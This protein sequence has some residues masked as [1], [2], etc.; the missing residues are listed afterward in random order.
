MPRSTSDAEVASVEAAMRSAGLP[1]WCVW[2]FAL[3]RSV[4]VDFMEDVDATLT[5]ATAGKSPSLLHVSRTHGVYR[6][7]YQPTLRQR[8]DIFIKP[9][10][11]AAGWASAPHFIGI[12]QP[13]A[14]RGGH[15]LQ[16]YLS[17][18][19]RPQAPAGQ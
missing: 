15:A 6:L 10:G 3:G 11:T 8:A 2:G 1:A 18:R 19:R 5:T 12:T 17:R 4:G 13:V 7:R 14:Q 16:A 9:S